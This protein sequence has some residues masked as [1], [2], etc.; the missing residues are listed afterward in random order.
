MQARAVIELVAEKEK[1][2][3]RCPEGEDQVPPS[4]LFWAMI[5]GGELVRDTCRRDA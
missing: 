3:H 2:I 1:A 5:S 4:S